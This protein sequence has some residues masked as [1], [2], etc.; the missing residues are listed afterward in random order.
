MGRQEFNIYFPLIKIA[1]VLVVGI[2]IGILFSNGFEL[3]NALEKFILPN[4][5]FDPVIDIWRDNYFG[6]FR[7]NQAIENIPAVDMD[8]T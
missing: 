5:Y 1:A 6:I 3:D 7:T 2:L 4:Y 8:A